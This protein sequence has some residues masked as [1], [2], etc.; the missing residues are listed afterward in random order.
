MLKSKKSQVICRK[1][2]QNQMQ[3]MQRRISNQEQ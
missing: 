2:E 3:K 1:R